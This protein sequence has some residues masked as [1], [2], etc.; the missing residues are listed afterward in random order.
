MI[1][2]NTDH[3]V[4]TLST[5]KKERKKNDL[6]VLQYCKQD[7]EACLLLYQTFIMKFFHENI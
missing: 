7:S 2:T 6:T 3:Y 1:C 4:N 5:I